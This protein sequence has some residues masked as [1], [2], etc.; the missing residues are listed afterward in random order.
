MPLQ[1]GMHERKVNFMRYKFWFEV[2]IPVDKAT[3]EVLQKLFQ[4]VANIIQPVCP[5]DDDDWDFCVAHDNF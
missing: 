5:F 3:D 2:D 4:D 1:S